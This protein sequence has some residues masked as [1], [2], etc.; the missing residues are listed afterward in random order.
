MTGRVYLP[1]NLIF[2]IKQYC[3]RTLPIESAENKSIRED[4]A[5]KEESGDINY[6]GQSNSELTKLAMDKCKFIEF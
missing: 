6:F 3:Y 2:P 5:N 1:S 4:L